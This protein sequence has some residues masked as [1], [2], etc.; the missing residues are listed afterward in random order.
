MAEVIDLS[1]RLIREKRRRQAQERRRAEAVAEA[2]ACGLCPHRCSHCGAVIDEYVLPLPEAP[3]PLCPTCTDELRAYLEYKRGEGS[4][5]A[6]WHNEQWE[7]MWE[8]WLA[9]MKAAQEFRRSPA[10]MRLM[11]HFPE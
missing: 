9:Y 8:S 10:F 11:Q 4:R 3:Y 7:R 1:Q 5:E 2:M 6:F